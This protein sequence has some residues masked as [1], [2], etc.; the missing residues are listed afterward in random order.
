M[1]QS[2]QPCAKTSGCPEVCI[3]KQC[4]RWI[5]E[6]PRFSH[7]SARPA[8][9]PRGPALP[10]VPPDEVTSCPA[11]CIL[12]LCR[13]PSFELPRLSRPSAHSVVKFRLPRSSFLRLHLPML[14]PGRPGFCIFR[15]CRRWLFESPRMSHPSAHLVL[16]PGVS[17][18]ASRSSCA[19][20]RI[21]P[22]CPRFLHL[23]A[24]PATDP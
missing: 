10:V 14:L 21:P 13:R 8:L 9:K 17:P 5:V 2:V 23:P 15:P 22:G 16:S 3:S 20:R 19:C 12:R 1:H 11:S 24:V 6:L 18:A 7:P 4:P